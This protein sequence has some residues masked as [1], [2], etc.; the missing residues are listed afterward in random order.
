MTLSPDRLREL[1]DYD[2]ATGIF[3]WRIGTRVV[4]AG[5]ECGFALKD[6]RRVICV[7]NETYQAG[8]LAW[9][10]VKGEWPSLEVDHRDCDPSNNRWKNLRE[11][12][13]SQNMANRGLQRNNTSGF[14]GVYPEGRKFFAQITVRR[15]VKRLGTFDTPAQA[16][17][18]YDAAAIAHF[19]E[20][21][22]TNA[23]SVPV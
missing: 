5:T 12:T 15:E 18:A 3:R 21:A 23:Q 20:F 6:G 9:F 1:I 22:R 10:Y 2:P 4:P 7:D 17:A 19:G 11:A 8:R 13:V 16:A 14:K